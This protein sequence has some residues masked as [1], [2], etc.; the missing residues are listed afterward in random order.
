M[1]RIELG[2][3]IP[4]WEWRTFGE[5]F[6]AAEENIRKYEC[7]RVI[8]S[9]EIYFISRN[10]DQNIKIRDD[11]MDI[12]ILKAVNE[13]KLEQWYPIMKASFPLGVE[14]TREVLTQSNA[15]HKLEGDLSLGLEDFIK[16][17]IDPNPDLAAVGVFK[18]RYG[19]IIDEAV[20]ELADLTIDG[21]SIRTTAVEHADPALVI[22]VVKALGLYGLE[23][24]NYIQAMKRMVEFQ[25]G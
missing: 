21:K 23:N 11:L 15:S 18:K 14:E 6:G 19:Y 17:I 25:K 4:R 2:K 13:D 22:R 7:T 20:V 8:E 16:Q 5:D 1:T 12:K 10:S 24:V 9:S 3:I